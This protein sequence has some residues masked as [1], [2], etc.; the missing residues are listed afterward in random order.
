MSKVLITGGAG[1]IGYH[2]A[3]HL[4]ANG[5]EL[6]IVDNFSRGVK[7]P[8]L[9]TLTS[10]S[11]VEAI[12][13]DLLDP[14]AM[15]KLADDYTYIF[16]L[17]AI[18]GVANVLNRPYSVLDD[19]VRLTTNMLKLA[20]RQKDLKRF[21]FASTS[22]V[23]AGTLKYFSME[24]PTPEST[25]LAI[26][27]LNHPR[28]SYMLSKIYGEALCNQSPVPTTNFRPHNIYGPRM[29]MAHVVP[30]LL[31]KC[32]EAGDS[33]T[34]EVF[35][36]DHKR[37]FCY[38]QDSVEMLLLMAE[39]DNCENETLN[40]G[41]Q[42][43]EIAIGDVARIIIDTVGNP[44]EIIPQ[45]ATAGSPTRRCP[46]MSKVTGL[47]NYTAGTGLEEGIGKT[48]DWYKATIFDAGG[49]TAK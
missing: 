45:E 46:D 49:I 37:T 28:T 23:Y 22:E 36:V 15:D 38:I 14:G 16:H 20:E 4:L 9:E 29:G 10:D 7:D 19:N 42:E 6:T 34:L 21:M 30:E 5:H 40:L 32:Y 41:N 13:M 39:S 18:I 27:D 1:F 25:P 44:L 26:T 11:R 47:I 2:L 31:K 17:A 33:K 43:P 48:F 12:T 35:S 3:N 8:E 24:I